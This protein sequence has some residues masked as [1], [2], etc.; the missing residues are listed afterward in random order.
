MLGA[1]LETF[2][3]NKV[4]MGLVAV[5]ALSTSWFVYAAFTTPSPDNGFKIFALLLTA[6]P[7][8]LFFGVQL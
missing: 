1:E 4:L 2:G 3:G 5:L 8:L 6:G 7:V